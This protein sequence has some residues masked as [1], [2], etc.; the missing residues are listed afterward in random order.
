VPYAKDVARVAAFY[1]EL[2]FEEHFRLPGEDSSPGHIGL[3]RDCAELAVTTEE[4]PRALAGIE[5]GAGPQHELFVYV[6]DVDATVA[7]LRE[8]G[9]SV[10]RAPSDMFWGDAWRGSWIPRATS[11][12]SRPRRPVPDAPLCAGRMSDAPLPG[13]LLVG[14]QRGWRWV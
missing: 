12:R 14:R 3:R 5:P 7:T 4:A 9:V 8:R 13:R 10:V 2:G 6:D 11:S 1:V